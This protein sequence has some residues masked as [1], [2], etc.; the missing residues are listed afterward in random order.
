MNKFFKLRITIDEKN[1]ETCKHL[2]Q[3]DKVQVT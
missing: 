3:K 1:Q 2:M